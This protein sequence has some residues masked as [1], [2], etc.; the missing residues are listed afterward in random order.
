MKM[1]R[2]EYVFAALLIAFISIFFLHYPK[3]YAID[4]EANILSLASSM[5]R[6]TVFLDQAGID[7]DADLVW[8]GHRISKFSPF[9]AALLAPAVATRW[10]LAF[11]VTAAFLVWGAFI[12]R[13][14]LRHEDL[15][16]DW[17]LLYFLNPGLLYYSRTLLGI[18]PAAVMGLLGASLLFRSRPRPLAGAMALGGAVLLH[19]WLAPVAI[20]LALGWW[21]EQKGGGARALLVL[22]LGAL[23]PTALFVLYNWATTGSPVRNAY[24][25]IGH[26]RV[27]NLSHGPEFLALYVVSLL[28]APMAGWAAFSHRW[29]GNWTLPVTVAAIIAIASTYYYRD[30]VNYGPVG[31]IPGQRFLLPAS[32]LACIPAARFIA[33]LSRR[34]QPSPLWLRRLRGAAVGAFLVG[35]ALISVYHQHYLQAQAA[36]QAAIRA[37]IPDGASVMSSDRVFKAFAP[38]NGTWTLRLARYGRV[39][40]E[41]EREGAYTVWLGL[42]GEQPPPGWFT[43]RSPS[44]TRAS[45]WVW[46]RDLWIAPP[47]GVGSATS[48]PGERGGSRGDG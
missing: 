41:E 22:S 32:L 2:N 14:M 3:T 17:T 5:A 31:W 18:V 16:S 4:D 39:P 23:P 6:G 42:P 12:L 28:V 8:Q 10:R 40:T 48:L 45:S 11:L 33:T 46:S 25:I 7:L 30:G 35:F 21:L 34:F 19:I 13:G 20:I 26:Q 36:V 44:V 24:W 29:A 38:V 9:H 1:T 27:L 37:A 47:L 15:S 43:G